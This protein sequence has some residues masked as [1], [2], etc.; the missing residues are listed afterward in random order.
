MTLSG[1]VWQSGG[2]AVPSGLSAKA[3]QRRK[4]DF[5]GGNKSSNSDKSGRGCFRNRACHPGSGSK[6]YL[7][8]ALRWHSSA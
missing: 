8:G 3:S 4:L 5:E 7:N 2:F 1:I 6:V